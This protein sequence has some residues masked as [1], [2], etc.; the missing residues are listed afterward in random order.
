MDDR[1]TFLKVTILRVYDYMN[2]EYPTTLKL[3]TNIDYQTAPSF[4][5]YTIK[6]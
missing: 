2:I 4:D 5:R 6:T 1:I 3:I